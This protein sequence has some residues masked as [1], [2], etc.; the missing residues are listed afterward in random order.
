MKIASCLLA[1]I[2]LIGQP[3]PPP[4]LPPPIVSQRW[5]VLRLARRKED[6]FHF[7]A[8]GFAIARPERTYVVTCAH[9]I[10][11]VGTGTPL[12]ADFQ[13][14]INAHATLVLAKSAD[15]DIAI[16]ATDVQISGR[17]QE[18]TGEGKRGMQVFL[19]GFDD[20]HTEKDRPQIQNGVIEAMGWWVEE[21]QHRLFTSST[22]TR[23]GAR[24]ML[25]SGL[26]CNPGVSGSPVFGPDGQIVAVTTAFTVDHRCL[27]TA[28]PL[29]IELLEQI[30]AGG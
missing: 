28:A 7:V 8:T 11:K 4:A 23:S 18:R 12:F 1:L 19:V 27:A 10:E 21:K 30:A 25:I 15:P 29:A 17:A 9:V 24:A 6:G 14:P 22:T 16:L 2:T 5:R 13:S 26:V 20:E 3:A